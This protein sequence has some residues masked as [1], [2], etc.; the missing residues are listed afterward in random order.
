[1][2]WILLVSLF[3][4]GCAHDRHLIDK[5]FFYEVSKG[6]H[7]G[8]IL[9]TVRMGVSAEELPEA[10]QKA[11][12]S[13][14]ALVLE[15]RYGNVD[16]S[17]RYSDSR[18]TPVRTLLS[19]AEYQA[20]LEWLNRAHSAEKAREIMEE[21]SPVGVAEHLSWARMCDHNYHECRPL[22][23]LQYQPL[24]KQLRSQLGARD[25]F[26]LATE[27]ASARVRKCLA[28]SDEKTLANIRSSL[29]GGNPAEAEFAKWSALEEAYRSGDE[30]RVAV[31]A[32]GFDSPEIYR[33]VVTA[34][35]PA[36]LSE[37]ETA[38]T[39]YRSPFITV[40]VAHLVAPLG[41]KSLLDLLR[42]DGY[43]VQRVEVEKV[44]HAH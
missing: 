44:R 28:W 8:V 11:F 31:V 20:T 27:E 33:C 23:N 16:L 35:N 19:P 40:A 18:A 24:E 4:V 43:A 37:I 15:S 2:R 25:L 42:E 1:M 9:G 21:D 6:A 41:S 22:M 32:S 36:W 3:M 29:T 30:K 14:D 13:A 7:H 12:D 5:P 38:L 26:Y 34:Q 39:R 10:V 17:D